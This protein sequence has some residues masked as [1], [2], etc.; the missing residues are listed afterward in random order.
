MGLDLRNCSVR[1][2]ILPPQP[3][4]T[5]GRMVCQFPR[6]TTKVKSSEQGL[7]PV[8]SSEVLAP[9]TALCS[10]YCGAFNS[11]VAEKI[12][13]SWDRKFIFCHLYFIV[14]SK[15]HSCLHQLVVREESVK[16]VK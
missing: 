13:K 5:V 12:S 6:E 15:A 7:A 4:I 14:V 8:K 10:D 2:I 1:D 16:W 11:T 9:V 3:R